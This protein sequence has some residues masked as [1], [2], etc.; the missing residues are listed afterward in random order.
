M[1]GELTASFMGPTF[2]GM[3][4]KRERQRREGEGKEDKGGNGAEGRRGPGTEP[5]P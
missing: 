1:L 2:N 5:P 3:E 4:R